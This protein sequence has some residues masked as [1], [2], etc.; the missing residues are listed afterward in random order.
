M[1]MGEKEVK[2][3]TPKEKVLA[4]KVAKPNSFEEAIPFKDA[5]AAENVR[6]ILL[7]GDTNS[8]N[9][10]EIQMDTLAREI[11]ANFS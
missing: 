10:R 6:V 8:P 11:K 9:F 2:P 7:I 5:I 1:A 4:S 3:E